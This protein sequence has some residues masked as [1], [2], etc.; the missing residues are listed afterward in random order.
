MM[1]KL[2]ITEEQAQIL[3]QMLKEEIYQMPVDKKANKP[4]CINPEKVL[5]VK[6]F[7]DKGF[8][9]HDYE[10][11][12]ENGM[13]TT[14][15]VVSMNASNGTPLKYMY[16]DQLKNLLIDRFQNMFTDKIEREL[17]LSKVLED[18]INGKIS[19]LGTLSTNR[20]M[21]ENLSKE[22]IDKRANDANPNPTEA[23][24]EAGNYKMGHISIAGMAISIEN[25]RGSK[26]V[27]KNEDG[28]EGYNIMKHHY[29]YFKLTDKKGK[30]GDAVDVFVGP[31]ID[32]I[33]NVYVVDQNSK[34]GSFDESK[35]MIGFN[36]IKDA[37]Q[38]Y[39]SNY[40]KD[41]KGFRCITGV[42]LKVFKDWLYRGRKQRKP[43]AEYVKIRKKQITEAQKTISEGNYGR[44][45][46]IATMNDTK[47][48][49]EVVEVLLN[50]E[51][52]A[53]RKGNNV[54]IEFELDRL[55]PKYATDIINF[56]KKIAQEYTQTHF[57]AIA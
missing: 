49:D 4:Y 14:I 29:G 5:I 8:T 7:L 42:P 24:K 34:D 39:L 22:E 1:R 50:N 44:R 55:D 19:S 38:A 28:S 45:E 27:Y 26:R 48:A 57:D 10:K 37:K 17:F 13:P 30:D 12:G 56:S 53:F 20:L 16:Q 18:W 36:N 43:F 9:A 3:S 25:P 47:A 2:I 35:V 46:I 21:S 40:S 52:D 32:N 41:W 33:T 6:N 51:I 54:Y 31:H 15:K 23:Q 11:I